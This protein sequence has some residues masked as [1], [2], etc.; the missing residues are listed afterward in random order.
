MRVVD[1]GA[2]IERDD[3]PL[4]VARFADASARS[5]PS[6]I[7]NVPPRSDSVARR[8]LHRRRRPPFDFQPPL[9]RAPRLEDRV[10]CGAGLRAG[11]GCPRRRHD[12]RCRG[13]L[14]QHAGAPQVPE[15]RVDRVLALPRSVHAHRAL[16]SRLS[17]GLDHAGACHVGSD[18][19]AVN[20]WARG[21]T[22][23]CI[24]A[25]LWYYIRNSKQGKERVMEP[26][27]RVALVTGASSGN[28]GGRRTRSRRRWVHGVRD[29]PQG[30]RGR[31]A[32]EAA[33]FL[34]LTSPMRRVGG[35]RGTRG[36]RPLGSYRRAGQQRRSRS[37]GRC[38]GELRGAGR[39][40][41]VYGLPGAI[42]MTRST[43]TSSTAAS[44]RV[45][46]VLGCGGGRLE[47]THASRSDTTGE[48]VR[49]PRRPGLPFIIMKG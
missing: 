20:R 23:H 12:S 33:V 34:P 13:P 26:T 37:H 24:I 28:W 2:G 31:D 47:Q 19:S 25:V 40:L 14:L 21:Q 32:R 16:A 11:T 22:R 45:S 7:S 43:S 49:G 10:R 3:L 8:S 48:F 1:D 29:E 42:R 15:E 18:P 39:V 36:A 30:D 44:R 27:G 38:R 4:A 5:P 41:F 6:R 35:R 17:D 46:P 9:G